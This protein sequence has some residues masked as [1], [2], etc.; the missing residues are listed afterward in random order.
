MFPLLVIFFL[1]TLSKFT[2]LFTDRKCVG[3]KMSESLL[4][5]TDEVSRLE[6]GRLMRFSQS[7]RLA[8]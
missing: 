8:V 3:L 6:M 2:S 7:V 5:P 4:C 1:V